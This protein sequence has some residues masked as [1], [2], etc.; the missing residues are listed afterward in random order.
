MRGHSPLAPELLHLRQYDVMPTDN[1][2]SVKDD[3]IAFI[4][5]LGLRR[6]PA[7]VTEEVPTV[8]FEE[9]DSDGWK[10]FVEHAKAAGATF[11]TMSEVTLEGEDVEMV[12]D[13]LRTQLREQPR[14]AD[15]EQGEFD[16]HD[17]QG[18]QR[19]VG[20]TG[21][22]QLGF[23]HGGVMYL[24]ESSTEWYERFQDLME[25]AAGLGGLVADDRDE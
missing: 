23:S 8:L 10:D 21:Y 24:H 17:A 25:T 3:M 11:L 7:Y 9:A 2:L 22:L 6:M 13:Q 15:R 1:L 12:V 14:G 20:K 5:G 18:L 4:A 16:L 19:H